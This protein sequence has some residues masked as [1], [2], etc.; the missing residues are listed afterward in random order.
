MKKHLFGFAIFSLI[1]GSAIFV[2]VIFS[3]PRE[4]TVPAVETVYELPVKSSCWKMKR[5]YAKKDSLAVRQAVLD[6]ETKEINFELYVP[7]TDSPVAMHFFVR[8]FEG[9][10][11]LATE[12]S[13]LLSSTNNGVLGFTKTYSWLKN[14]DSYQNLYVVPEQISRRDY[15]LGISNPKFVEDK[16]FAVTV[17][18][19]KAFYK[20]V[21]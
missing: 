1:V 15:E 12:L 7:K 20:S 6:L 4:V 8:D 16:A 19:G 9:T 21:R 14:P 2:S 10:R 11:Y 17:N 13:P 18:S 3:A 5:E